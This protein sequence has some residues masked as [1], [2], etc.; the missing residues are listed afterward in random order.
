MQVIKKRILLEKLRSRSYDSTWGTITATSINILFEINQSIKDLG[1]YQPYDYIKK[2]EINP[3]TG[4]LVDYTSLINKIGADGTFEFIN[5]PNAMFTTNKT[6]YDYD[7]RYN[8]KKLSD[9]YQSGFSIS[10]ITDDKLELFGSYGF[11]G[12]SKYK[13][14]KVIEVDLF[15]N[16]TGKTF[17]ASS[18]VLSN[19]NFNPI[20]YVHMG[21]L[22]DNRLSETTPPYLNDGILYETFSSIT[23]SV[24]TE[25][26]TE[27]I[28][29]TNFYFKGQ[30]LNNSNLNM[31]A[32]TRDEYLL[33]ITE[34][35]KV[36]SEVFIERGG[37]IIFAKHGRMA[38]I[39][40]LT[41]L[42]KYG[43][44]LYK[45]NKV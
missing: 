24:K 2:G 43:N 16:H 4:K 44:G 17:A 39:N 23:R 30:G 27:E 36:E 7:T 5:N 32:L 20:T 9:Y 29:L 3:E 42:E 34:E 8:D 45:I 26:G 22:N 11:T 25:F 31:S 10:G 6:P 15:E 35:P 37:S 28:P 21:D 1:A 38:E 33:Y 14:G 41:Q 18:L 12:D 13:V 19:N 40:N